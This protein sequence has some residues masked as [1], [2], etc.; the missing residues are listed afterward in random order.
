MSGAEGAAVW[1]GAQRH[2]WNL[3]PRTDKIRVM[4]LQQRVAAAAKLSRGRAR[5]AWI[6]SFQ[7]GKVRVRVSRGRGLPPLRLRGAGRGRGTGG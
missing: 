3:P 6:L 4:I 7:T 2:P 5:L 1:G